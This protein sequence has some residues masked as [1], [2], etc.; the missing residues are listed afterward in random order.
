MAVTLL[1]LLALHTLHFAFA[2]VLGEYLPQILHVKVLR[3]VFLEYGLPLKW[4]ELRAGVYA[5]LCVNQ[6]SGA[7]KLVARGRGRR[8]R[9]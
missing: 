6:H 2:D 9:R 3:D 8:R 5:G 7:T 1:S 4:T